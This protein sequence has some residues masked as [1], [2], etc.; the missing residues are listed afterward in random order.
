MRITSKQLRAI[1]N[2][3]ITNVVSEARTS[4]KAQRAAAA[5]RLR[6]KYALEPVGELG[7]DPESPGRAYIDRGLQAELGISTVEDLAAA[8]ESG[9]VDVWSYFMLGGAMPT[10]YTVV[11]KGSS[12]FNDPDTGEKG[13][14][15]VVIKA[16]RFGADGERELGVSIQRGTGGGAPPQVIDPGSI[17]SSVTDVI[18]VDLKVGGGPLMERMNL[19]A[20]TRRR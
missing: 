6:S 10:T 1:I 2:E 14:P 20:G 5:E 19:L 16:K 18:P 3:E 13:Y 4:V 12:P 17:M 11:P 7:E 9:S 15:Y 8:A